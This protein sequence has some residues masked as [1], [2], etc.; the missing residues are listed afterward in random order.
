MK[1]VKNFYESVNDYLDTFIPLINLEEERDKLN[2]DWL[3][4]PNITIEWGWTENKWRKATLTI[5]KED[6]DHVTMG[7]EV[8][9]EGIDDS[10]GILFTARGQI[11]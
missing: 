7:D 5:L 6:S 8:F 11:Y 10:L 1:P 4:C 9:I 2:K 3:K